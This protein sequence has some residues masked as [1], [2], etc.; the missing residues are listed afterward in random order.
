MREHCEIHFLIT[1][2]NITDNLLLDRNR[3]R[4][5]IRILIDETIN[6]GACSR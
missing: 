5:S 3:G 4:D 6:G 2:R 1:L